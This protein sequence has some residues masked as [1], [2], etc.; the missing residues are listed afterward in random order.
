MRLS[1]ER[2]LCLEVTPNGGRWWWLRSRSGG[3]EKLISLGTCPDTGLK[4]AR[5]SGERRGPGDE[6]ADGQDRLPRDRPARLPR[7]R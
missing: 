7:N 3:K 1:D 4:A 5:R 2:G 6:S